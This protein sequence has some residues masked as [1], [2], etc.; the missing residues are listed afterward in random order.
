MND[1]NN[2][3]EDLVKKFYIKFNKLQIDG[4]HSLSAR[5]YRSVSPSK[6]NAAMFNVVQ[7]KR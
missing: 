6:R 1:C 3:F 5:P 4:F 7:N 2:M